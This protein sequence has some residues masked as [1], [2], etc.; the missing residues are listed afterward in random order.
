MIEFIGTLVGLS[1]D[2]VLWLAIAVVIY[3]A[4]ETRTFVI[5]LFCASIA[6]LALRMMLPGF[7]PIYALGSILILVVVSLIGFAIRSRR[8]P[9]AN[10][11]PEFRE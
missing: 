5:A 6:I 9:A 8:Q 11:Q 4:K 10:N 2:P 1:A 3:H 7:V